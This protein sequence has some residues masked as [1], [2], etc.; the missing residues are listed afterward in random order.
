MN[1]EVTPM[2]ASRKSNPSPRRQHPPGCTSRKVPR[3]SAGGDCYH[4]LAVGVALAAPMASAQEALRN[5]IAGEAAAQARRLQLEPLPYTIKSGDFRLLATPALDV[6]WNDNIRL[7]KDNPEE[8]LIVRPTMGFIANYPLTQRN[9][10]QLN[11]SVGY[12]EYVRH[13]DLSQW[14]IQSGSELSFDVSVKDF[15]INFHDRFSYIQD[16]AQEAAVANTGSYG[17]LQNSAG[18]N[19][20]WDLE[21][22]VLSLGY[23]HQNVMSTAQEFNSQNHASEMVVSRAGLK[24]NPRLTTGL[25][26]TAAFTSYEEKILNNNQNYSAGLYADWQ[27]GPALHVQPRGGYTITH[28][29]LTSLSGFQP[30]PQPVRTSDLSSWYADLT[31]SHQVTEAITYSFSAGHEIRLGIQSDAIEDSYF[32]PAITWSVVRNV[33]LTTSFFYE[34]GNQG[35]GNISG[36]F[37]ETY[38]WYGGVLS[39]GY[40]VMKKLKMSMNY[41]L[42]LRSSDVPSREY[43]QNV[44]G[45]L[46]T[47][48]L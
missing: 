6:D 7:A 48:Q 33:S 9:L 34:H 19:T 20:T 25:E 2:A 24:L 29:D 31:V 28:F 10:L 16:S 46:L 36:N 3:V 21:D 11:V 18:V 41:R 8:D 1:F 39:V 47:Y 5:S 22:V 12:N 17:T 13:S 26:G 38:D 15:L 44:V 23:D 45:L 35:E 43:A 40:P 30:F 27:P 42:T 32:R 37:S 14:Y 4:W